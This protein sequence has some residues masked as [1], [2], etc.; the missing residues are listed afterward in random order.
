MSFYVPVVFAIVGTVLY[1]LSQKMMPAKAN[2]FLCL[3]FAFGLAC[4]L[5]VVLWR[6]TTNAQDSPVA[7][8]WQSLALGFALVAIEGGYLFAYRGGWQLNR[9]SLSANVSVAIILVLIG[10]IWFKEPFSL[11]LVAGIG[12]CLVGLALLLH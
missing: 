4:I 9:A 11:R 2:A 7:L 12:S 10:A 8:P 6:V 1:H 3:A 5:S